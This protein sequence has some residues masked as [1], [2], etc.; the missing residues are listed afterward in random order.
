MHI[1][2]NDFD[3]LESGGVQLVR[4]PARS[5][6]DVRLVLAFG[7]DAG[8]TQEFAKLAEM[9]VA[10]FFDEVGKVH[11]TLRSEHDS[12]NGGAVDKLRL[13]GGLTEAGCRRTARNG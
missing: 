1:G 3:C 4:H 13:N 8:N 2:R 6:F 10:M 5:A 7:A 9:H 12:K 11:G